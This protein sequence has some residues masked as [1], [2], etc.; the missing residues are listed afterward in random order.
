[1]K[2]LDWFK[3]EFRQQAELFGCDKMPDDLQRVFME[4][5]P[6][7]REYFNS[8]APLDLPACLESSEIESCNSWMHCRYL[9]ECAR[10]YVG[11]LVA[12]WSW[13]A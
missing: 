2:G 12:G 11:R 1:M 7:V 9:S 13:E 8:L 6:G 4:C 3:S 5:P 10:G